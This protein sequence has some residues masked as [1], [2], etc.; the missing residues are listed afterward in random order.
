MEIPEPVRRQAMHPFSELP[1]PVGWKRVEGEHV[2]VCF[3]TY[4]I[5]QVVAT[6]GD[7]KLA[8]NMVTQPEDQSE[9]RR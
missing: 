4:P 5:A 2:R 1:L 8:V 9:R 7:A 3:H 6:L